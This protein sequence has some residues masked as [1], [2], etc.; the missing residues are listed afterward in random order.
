MADEILPAYTVEFRPAREPTSV[1]V[2][3][4]ADGPDASASTLS[5]VRASD[6]R[7]EQ[8]A[9]LWPGRI[10]RGKL[11]MVAGNPGLGKSQLALNLASTCT[12]GGAW[13]VNEGRAPLGSVVILSAE[14]DVADTIRPRLEAAG[15]DLDRVHVVDAVRERG[16]SRGFDLQRDLALLREAID[17][18]GDV[19]LVIIDAI[20]AYMGKVDTHRTSDVRAALAPLTALAS[21]TG[22]AVVAVSH[23]NK[24]G[25]AEAM[26]RVTGSLA[27]VAAARAGYLIAK[28]KEDESRRLFLPIKNN[29][30]VD[31]TGFAY[32]VEPVDLGGGIVAPRVV[33]EDEH[34]Q[35]TADEALAGSSAQVEQD[36]GG[37]ALGEAMQFLRDTLADGPLPAKVIFAMSDEAGISKKTL[38]RAQERIR[39]KPTKAGFGG[40][41]MWAL[42]GQEPKVVKDPE[43]AQPESM[44]I[45]EEDGH[46]R[47]SEEASTDAG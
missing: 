15:A 25:G 44:G 39:I 11:T 7:A 23:L 6:V 45:F 34:V 36:G 37:S 27:F 12:R 29:L 2:N 43:G 13:P 31:N 41:W 3:P 9:W 21:E 18:I 46:L 16:G 40:Q 5:L 1:G 47:P 24:G 17:R 38:R 26:M 30:G 19:V 35:T 22:A 28:D 42:F 32:A 10:A 8:V 14:D 33:F 20:T 4:R